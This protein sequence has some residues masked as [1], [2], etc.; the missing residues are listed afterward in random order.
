MSDFE[1]LMS[2]I[3][4]EA[5]KDKKQDK[6]LRCYVSIGS[7]CIIL[8]ALLFMVNAFVS[9]NYKPYFIGATLILESVLIM[10]LILI[11][12]RAAKMVKDIKDME[13]KG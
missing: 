7:V 11:V 5:A 1:L 10:C 4:T 8:C 13:D 3:R 6:R 12:I 9:V 2:S